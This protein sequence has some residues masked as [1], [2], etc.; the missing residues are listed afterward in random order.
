MCVC[1]MPWYVRGVRD[2]QVQH[3]HAYIPVSVCQREGGG[4]V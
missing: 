3:S 2:E 1:S 4:L